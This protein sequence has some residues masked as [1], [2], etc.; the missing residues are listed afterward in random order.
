VLLQMVF[1]VAKV[2]M[3]HQLVLNGQ[4]APVSAHQHLLPAQRVVIRASVPRPDPVNKSIQCPIAFS[5]YGTFF[6]KS[7][8][9]QIIFVL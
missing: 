4:V 1:P 8:V 2:L 9:P 5:G 3:D 7:Y 6:Q